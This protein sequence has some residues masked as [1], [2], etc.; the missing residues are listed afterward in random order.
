MLFGTFSQFIDFS[1]MCSLEDRK[2]NPKACEWNIELWFWIWAYHIVIP[3]SWLDI[4]NLIRQ[5][6]YKRKSTTDYLFSLRS[7]VFSKGSEKQTNITLTS[8]K[9]DYKAAISVTSEAIWL[10]RVL[11]NLNLQQNQVMLSFVTTKVLFN[12]KI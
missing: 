12:T 2:K 1:K 9:T 7:R 8:M 3:S 11:G 4:L 10:G 6:A 5:D